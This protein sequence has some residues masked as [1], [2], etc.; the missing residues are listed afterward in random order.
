MVENTSERPAAR[1]RPSRR[2]V[3]GG[4]AAASITGFPYI[5][6]GFAAQTLKFWQFYGPGGGVA[7]QDKWFVDLAKSWNESH[8]VRARLRS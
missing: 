1:R 7:T 3:L 4:I 6:R 2:T 8:E 5:S